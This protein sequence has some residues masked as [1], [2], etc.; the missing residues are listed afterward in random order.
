MCDNANLQ[1]SDQVAA[2]DFNNFLDIPVF[3]TNDVTYS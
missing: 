3:V 2:T 1:L